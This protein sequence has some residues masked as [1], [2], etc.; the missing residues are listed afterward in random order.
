MDK[1]LKLR[2]LR[3]QNHMIIYNHFLPYSSILY[4]QFSKFLT[5]LS[6]NDF[7]N[8]IKKLETIQKWCEDWLKDEWSCLGRRYQIES[9]FLSSTIQNF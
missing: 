6:N 4:I 3:N 9:I 8:A 5:D 2:D 1:W 7:D